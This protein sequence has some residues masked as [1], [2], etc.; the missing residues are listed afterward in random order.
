MENTQTTA[1]SE[2]AIELR[3]P[4]SAINIVL[5]GLDSLPHK[6]SRRVF[7]EIIKQA[8]AQSQQQAPAEVAHT[9][10]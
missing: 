3:L 5:E 2:V 8:Q 1:A 10:D 7:D 9:I 4:V 6:V